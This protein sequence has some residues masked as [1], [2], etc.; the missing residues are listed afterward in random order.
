MFIKFKKLSNVKS[1]NFKSNFIC[2]MI[3]Q[4]CSTG[5]DFTNQL[6][7]LWTRVCDYIDSNSLY[8]SLCVCAVIENSDFIREWEIRKLL[9][10]ITYEVK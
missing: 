8:E 3:G 10:G 5:L 2:N 6:A 7:C 4:K 1:T 9:N